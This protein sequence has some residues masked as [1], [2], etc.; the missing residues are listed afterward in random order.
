MK[1]L[2]KKRK[3]VLLFGLILIVVGIIFITINI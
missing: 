1:K 2:D 3:V